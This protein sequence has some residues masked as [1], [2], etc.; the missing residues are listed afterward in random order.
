M[1]LCAESGPSGTIADISERTPSDQISLYV[2]RPGDTISQIA[3]MYGVTSNTIVWANNLPSKGT[4]IQ[5]GDTLVILPV[6]GIKHTVAK[7]ETIQSIVKKYK[8]YLTEVLQYNGLAEG[9]S[10]TVGQ[11]IIIPGGE[12]I[13]ISSG[14]TSIAKT[15]PL[16]GASG[17]SYDGY[18]IWPVSGGRVTQGLHGYNGVDIGAP[19]GTPILAAAG[20]TIIIARDSGWNGGYGEYVVIT[21]ENGTQTLYSHM[22]RVIVSP[23]Q[24][25]AGSQV[26]GYIGQT[27][28]ATGPHL[29]FEVRGAKNPFAK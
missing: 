15:A 7:G 11:E 13:Q 23:G 1:A 6:T 25:V 18:Y 12:E 21:H 28:K 14:S 24:Y 16:R 29:H 3:K 26:I 19:I 2:V 22:S 27:G 10:L 20:G 8:G 9:A 5:P 4:R 17:P